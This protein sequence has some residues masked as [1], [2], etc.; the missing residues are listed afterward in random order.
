MTGN[1]QTT[2]NSSSNSTT[3]TTPDPG[4]MDIWNNI[5]GTGG[6]LS[7]YLINHNPPQAT[8]A[9]PTDLTNQF[10]KQAGANSTAPDMTGFQRGMTDAGG[11]AINQYRDPNQINLPGQFN[12]QPGQIDFNNPFAGGTPNV[13]APT[14]GPSGLASSY[15]VNPQQVQAERIAAQQV[16]A[17]GA[18]NPITGLMQVYGPQL[19]NYQMG[20]AQTV[21]APQ[22]KDFTMQAAANVAPQGQVGTQSWADPSTQQ[23][24]MSPYMQQVVDQAK[25]RAN[26][27]FQT[28]QESQRSQAVAAGAY[29]GSRQAVLEGTGARDLQEHLGDIQSQGLQAAYQQA[30]QQFNQEQAARQQAQQFNIGTGLQAALANQ[31][32][33]Q[34]A[35][36]Q[37]LSSFLQTQGL[38]AQTGLQADLANQA[39]GINV[40][41]QNLQANLQTQGLGATLG[42]QAQRAKQSQGLQAALANQQAQEFGSGQQMQASLA[43]QQAALQAALANQSTGLQGQMSN[44]G[45]G[46]QAGLAAQNLGFQGAQFNAQQGMQAQLANQAAMMQALGMQYQGGLQ[47]ALQTQQL[48][49]QGQ[50]AGGQLGLQG[51]QAQE[52]LRQSQMSQNMNAFNMAGNL[53]NQAGNLGLNGYNS[54]L[55]GQNALAQAAMGQ[56]GMAQ[57]RA[58]TAF[59]NNMQNMMT[60]LQAQAWMANLLGMAPMST[61]TTQ[62][63]TSTGT[64]TQ[65]SPSLLSQILGGGM[66]AAG[67]LGKMFGF[68]QGGPVE[69]EKKTGLAL[70]A[71]RK[72]KAKADG[73]AAVRKAA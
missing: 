7:D 54:G 61:T 17:P 9:G 31:Q 18:I 45:A 25:V 3:T 63:G 58:D 62:Q 42:Q 71:P 36:L 50:I 13:S 34:Q 73:L 39:A 30:Q 48:G 14:N 28:Q 38:G 59:Q 10:W 57:Q 55:Q 20:P 8:V 67:M 19:Q 23:G 65:P 27:D 35:N 64:M 70:V 43:N 41:G 5:I 68:S 12:F 11:A 66:G 32:M 1:P 21:N 4:R 6:G 40:G 29:G 26:E 56:Q 69:T 16:S 24:L 2:S 15:L 47:G 46:L 60:P 72:R 52:Q 49:M 53:Y 44:Q 51:Q 37:N 33:Q 22:L